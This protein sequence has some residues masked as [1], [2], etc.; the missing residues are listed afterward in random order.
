[1]NLRSA[2]W[3]GISANRR[4]VVEKFPFVTNIFEVFKNRAALLELDRVKAE[5]AK[6]SAAPP[7]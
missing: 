2:D 4:D 5:K 6:P 1:V 7:K 3:K